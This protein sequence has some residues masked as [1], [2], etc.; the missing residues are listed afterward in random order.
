MAPEQGNALVKQKSGAR[1]GPV[2]VK[3]SGCFNILCH[4]KVPLL[5]KKVAPEQE[6]IIPNCFWLPI[7]VPIEAIQS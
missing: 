4:I 2:N 5:K 1:A 7:R 6:Q 3:K